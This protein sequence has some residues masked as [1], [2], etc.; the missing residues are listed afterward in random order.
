MTKTKTT[1]TTSTRSSRG[2]KLPY[3]TNDVVI[4]EAGQSP[5]TLVVPVDVPAGD[6]AEVLRRLY[7]EHVKPLP[8]G[9]EQETHWKGPCA[10]E[11]PAAIADDV[12]DAMN[13]M[14][15]L[16][17]DRRALPGARVR[18]YSEGYWAHGF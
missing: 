16:V 11:V 12:A 8:F 9:P 1:R 3:A 2:R 6:R 10:A 15:S 17:D 13:F 5:V 18:L 14:G 7:S 4:A